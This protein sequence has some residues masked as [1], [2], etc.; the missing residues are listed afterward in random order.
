MNNAKTM[1]KETSFAVITER[2]SL[3]CELIYDRENGRCFH[4]L[5]PKGKPYNLR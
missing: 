1:T 4:Q 3:G 2:M 5:L